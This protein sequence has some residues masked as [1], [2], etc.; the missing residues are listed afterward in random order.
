[1]DDVGSQNIRS[2][3][4]LNLPQNN[5]RDRTGNSGLCRPRWVAGHGSPSHREI[6]TDVSWRTP[7]AQLLLLRDFRTC[8][9]NH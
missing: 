3:I 5:H 7:S 9:I 2:R 8:P 4:Q 1:M 6:P